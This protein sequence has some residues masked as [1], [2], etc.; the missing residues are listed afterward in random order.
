IFT[1]FVGVILVVTLA[2]TTRADISLTLKNKPYLPPPIQE[3][4]IND[5]YYTGTQENAQQQQQQEQTFKEANYGN[6]LYQIYEVHNHYDASK[7]NGE[8]VSNEHLPVQENASSSKA[9]EIRIEHINAPEDFP[10]D[11]PNLDASYIGLAGEGESQQEII[12]KHEFKSEKDSTNNIPIPFPSNYRHNFP[13]KSSKQHVQQSVVENSNRQHQS[14]KQQDYSRGPQ[15]NSLT[16][17]NEVHKSSQKLGHKKE[18]LPPIP[19]KSVAGGS[20]A[21]T[22]SSKPFKGADYLP[23][24]QRQDSVQSQ[25]KTFSRGSQ[26]NGVSHTQSFVQNKAFKGPD[27]LP[28]RQ[29]QEQ[30]QQYQQNFAQKTQFNVPSQQHQQ[31][32]QGVLYPQ[33]QQH[34]QRS[35]GALHPQ[36]QQHQQRSQGALH[37][38]QHLAQ[39]VP[40]KGPDYLPPYQH[41]QQQPH[42]IQSQQNLPYKGTHQFTTQAQQQNYSPNTPFKGPDYLPPH[43][44]LQSSGQSISH[45]NSQTH[46]SVNLQH[47][48]QQNQVF[49]PSAPDYFSSHQNQKIQ[50]TPPYKG[51]DYLPPHPHQQAGTQQVL[52]TTDYSHPQ[53]QQQAHSQLLRNNAFKGPDYLPPRQEERNTNTPFKGPD[54]LPPVQHQGNQ[55][56]QTAGHQPQIQEQQIGSLPPGY[57]FQKPANAEQAIAELHTLPEEQSEPHYK[58]VTVQSQL[59]VSG[60]QQSGDIIYGSSKQ[61]IAPQNSRTYQVP[62]YL[63]PG[64]VSTQPGNFENAIQRLHSQVRQPF[65]GPD[66]LPPVNQIQSQGPLVQQTNI[67]GHLPQGY[68]L[69]KPV[70]AEQ[71]INTLHGQQNS[72]QP[73][74][75]NQQAQ[76]TQAGQNN[77][78]QAVQTY[79]QSSSQ[80]QT[81]PPIQSKQSFQQ[82]DRPAQQQFKGPDYLPPV[83]GAQLF[84]GPDYLPPKTTTGSETFRG[85]DYLPPIKDSEVFKGPDYLP[86][87]STGSHVFKGPDY[88]PPKTSG[89]TFAT[90]NNHQVSQV[91]KGPEYLPPVANVKPVQNLFRGP[92]YLPP[93]KSIVTHSLQHAVVHPL[94]GYMNYVKPSDRYANERKPF[95]EY[96]LPPAVTTPVTSNNEVAPMY[97]ELSTRPQYYAPAMSYTT[98][99]TRNQQKIS[100]DFNQKTRET[101][102][103]F[104]PQEIMQQIS[105]ALQT[106]SKETTTTT[107]VQTAE[108]ANKPVASKVRTVQIANSKSVKTLKVLETLDQSGV[109][110]IKILGPSLEEP[111]GEHRVIKVVGSGD[112]KNVHTLKIFNDHHDVTASDAQQSPTNDYLPPRQKRNSSK[113]MKV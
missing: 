86:P 72:Y 15:Q 103:T 83:T 63:P 111:M 21:Q 69:P 82:L 79:Q 13:E 14:Q 73:I 94:S 71:A 47:Q 62:G 59:Q 27:Y 29:H 85:P 76:I 75:L 30:Q 10:L 18:Y 112:E 40:F 60:Q 54:Y 5:D 49:R 16:T 28:P 32:S 43:Q 1:R 48:Q 11:D 17:R 50:N 102:E 9:K 39:N 90:V 80:H 45:Q 91:F 23:P 24:P 98:Y 61:A 64:H 109:K 84:K 56:Q 65:K 52:K 46:V 44:Q 35:Q 42:V 34:Q 66:Y 104:M 97:R 96:G 88:L 107:A 38:Q 4:P 41:Q 25:Q 26:N 3:V 58:E 8:S 95:A 105:N 99:E 93:T 6:N 78:H 33:Q 100:S 81:V 57:D 31:R 70:N 2:T 36:Q 19:T 7:G 12:V 113:E 20:H 87:V 77:G 67:P 89:Q 55:Q 108:K 53:P 106:Q 110:T 51:P 74:Q 68:D 101:L 92:D 22:A 37:P